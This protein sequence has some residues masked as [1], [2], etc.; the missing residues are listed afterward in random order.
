MTS[1]ARVV[2]PVFKTNINGTEIL[3]FD[4]YYQYEENGEIIR[5]PLSNLIIDE[6]KIK[7]KYE[8]KWYDFIVK[9]DEEKGREYKY[10]YTCTGLAANELGKTGFSIELDTEL[11]NNI[12]T[13]QQ[14]GEKILEGSDW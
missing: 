13:V 5:N 9:K 1:P 8:N 7:L 4:I 14:L 12:G 6:R 2:N 10:S 11:E 3:T